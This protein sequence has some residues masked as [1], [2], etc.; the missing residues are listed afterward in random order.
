MSG[1]GANTSTSW[2]NV[3]CRKPVTLLVFTSPYCP[4]CEAY[5][6]ILESFWER[7]RKRNLA[8]KVSIVE[9]DATENP[10]LAEELGVY[11]TPTTIVYV[12]C[13]PVDGFVGLVDEEYLEEMVERYLASIGGS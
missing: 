9:V 12:N 11:A 13:R 5:R 3:T 2:G 4:Y 8:E 10:E 6:Y 1:E 7:A